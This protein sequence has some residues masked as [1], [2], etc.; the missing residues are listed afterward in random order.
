MATKVGTI[1]W[2]KGK[3]WP[4]EIIEKF[5]VAHRGKK[6]SEE[7]KRNIS[8]ANKGRVFTKEHKE[9]I[10]K[11][12]KGI[13][14][15][16]EHRA[17]LSRANKRRM[18]NKKLRKGISEKLKGR[19][20]PPSVCIKM[21]VARSGNK[22]WNWKGGISGKDRLERLKFRNLIQKRVFE[23]DNYTCQMCGSKKNLQ[24]D[25][26]QKWSEYIELRFDMNNCRTL[27]VK[28]HYLVTFGKPMPENVTGWGHNFLKGGGA[29]FN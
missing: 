26:I 15:S 22:N 5:R 27:C 20:L 9:K 8:K 16:E 29:Y 28:C 21:G 12:R 14:F 18:L 17:A 11:R 1:P 6:L 4:E 10:S 19:K 25:H 24:V 7:H 13:I 3:K 2:N 23:R